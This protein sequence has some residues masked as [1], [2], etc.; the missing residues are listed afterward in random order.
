MLVAKRES[1]DLKGLAGH[2]MGVVVSKSMTTNVIAWKA[3]PFV[4]LPMYFP[5]PWGPWRRRPSPGSSRM[6]MPEGLLPRYASL[7]DEADNG[8]RGVLQVRRVTEA[9]AGPGL[10]QG[11]A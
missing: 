3:G 10:A 4:K 5:F 2:P 9:L 6:S 1:S 8:L 7:A 11:P